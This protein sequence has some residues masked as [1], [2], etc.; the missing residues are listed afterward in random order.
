MTILTELL[1][2]LGTLIIGQTEC[3][4]FWN[5][6]I[7]N[8]LLLIPLSLIILLK[9]GREI[10]K[11]EVIIRALIFSIINM[12]SIYKVDG[13]EATIVPLTIISMEILLYTLFN[14][15]VSIRRFSKELTMAMIAL[16]I[17][18]IGIAGV[19][20]INNIIPRYIIVIELSVSIIFLIIFEILARKWQNSLM[21]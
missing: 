2:L 19:I 17:I 14:S 15:S 10:G 4:D 12:V 16:L 18:I 5:V 7:I 13:K 20:L 9:N 3:L 11:N 8:G 21:R 1:V 6:I